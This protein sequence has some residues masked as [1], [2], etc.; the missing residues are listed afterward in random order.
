ML[1]LLIFNNSSNISSHFFSSFSKSLVIISPLWFKLLISLLL[2]F[3]DKSIFTVFGSN[4]GILTF[5]EIFL[6]YSS[7][8]LSAFTFNPKA[9]EIIVEYLLTKRKHKSLFGS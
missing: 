6:I 8:S 9:R 5:D 2:L 3:S 4:F 1:F 7:E